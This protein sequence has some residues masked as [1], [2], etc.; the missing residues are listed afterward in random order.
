LTWREARSSATCALSTM[1]ASVAGLSMVVIF[2]FSGL[3]WFGWD[4]SV[5]LVVRRVMGT[6]E[7]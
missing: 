1:T 7:K 4:L 5:V 3:V 6:K 2:V